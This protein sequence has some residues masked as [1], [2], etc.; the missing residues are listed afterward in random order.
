KEKTVLYRQHSSN[1]SGSHDNNS[2]KKR[3]RRIV[4]NKKNFA[5]AKAKYVMLLTFKKKYYKDLHP[6]YRNK[7]DTFISIFNKKNPL[8]FIKNIKNGVRSQT[9]AQSLLLYVTILF[10]KTPSRL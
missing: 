7:L 1:V 8:M 5:E 10:T 4:V 2:W 9:L 6:T 3:F